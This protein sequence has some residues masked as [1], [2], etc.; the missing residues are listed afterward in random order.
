MFGPTNPTY[1]M[2]V[3]ADLIDSLKEALSWDPPFGW[4]PGEREIH[5]ENE[6]DGH[7]MMLSERT[8]R[9]YDEC[10]SRLLQAVGIE[11]D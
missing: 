10:R 4:S 8:G 7:T 5:D 1:D 11:E 2:I 6:N 9:G 3:P